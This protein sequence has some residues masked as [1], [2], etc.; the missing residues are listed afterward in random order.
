MGASDLV[1]QLGE[2]VPECKYVY[3]FIIPLPFHFRVQDTLAPPFS[4]FFRTRQYSFI[5]LYIIISLLSAILCFSPAILSIGWGQPFFSVGRRTQTVTRCQC[6]HPIDSGSLRCSP[7]NFQTFG[8]RLA[9]QRCSHKITVTQCSS[10]SQN[11]GGTV[12]HISADRTR[13]KSF[14]T[15]LGV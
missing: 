12:A 6:F 8:D 7:S 15:R 4:P 9:I 13:N 3:I 5:F 10:Y 11:S 1:S 14:R 2:G